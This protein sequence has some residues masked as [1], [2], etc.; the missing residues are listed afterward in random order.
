MSEG[1][2]SDYIYVPGTILLA[3]KGKHRSIR[4]FFVNAGSGSGSQRRAGLTFAA[5]RRRMSGGTKMRRLRKEDQGNAV[6][7]YV[8]L[9]VLVALGV[10][11]A[12]M[13]FGVN[14]RNLFSSA[15]ANV[16]GSGAHQVHNPPNHPPTGTIE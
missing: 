2:R 12:I 10:I 3:A 11:A 1:L 7:E 9:V 8:L 5:P 4:Q 16:H 14:L 15:A 13:G 6:T